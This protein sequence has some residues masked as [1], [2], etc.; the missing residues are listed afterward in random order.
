MINS[1]S[2][3]N[4]IHLTFVKEIGLPIRPIEVEKQKI[5]HTILDIY[6]IIVVAFSVAN[7]AY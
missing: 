5:H 7:K 2:E 3:V 4:A 6:G 1:K